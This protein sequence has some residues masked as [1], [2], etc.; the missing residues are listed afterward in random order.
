MAFFQGSIIMLGTVLWFQD[1]YTNITTITFSAL[2]IIELF[3]IHMCMHL[4]NWK[5]IAVQFISIIL[6]LVSVA[7]LCKPLECT[8][9]TWAFVIKI[10][11]LVVISWLPLY[12]INKIKKKCD[13][14]QY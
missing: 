9:I 13:P 8:Y 7:F 10:V 12:L 14:T 4:L 6:Y 3:N 11:A 5:M 1:A 2:I